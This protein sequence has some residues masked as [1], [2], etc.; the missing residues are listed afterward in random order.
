M[1]SDSCALTRLLNLDRVAK[2][3]RDFG[4]FA[5]SVSIPIRT[6]YCLAPMN[7]S[8]L[9]HHIHCSVAD[10][11]R[12]ETSTPSRSEL[13]KGQKALCSNSSFDLFSFACVVFGML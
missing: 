11:S 8:C 7:F 1:Y 10:G 2:S 12:I 5:V 9:A 3:W 6:H 4:L 13:Q